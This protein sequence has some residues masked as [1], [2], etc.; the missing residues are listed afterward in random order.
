V[1]RP[2]ADAS[3]SA[4]AQPPD[5]DLVETETIRMLRFQR[6]DPEKVPGDPGEQR[7]L[8]GGGGIHTPRLIALSKTEGKRKPRARR[9]QSPASYR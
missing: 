3:S 5:R 8:F 6:L 9:T 2:A 7:V 4:R 1:L